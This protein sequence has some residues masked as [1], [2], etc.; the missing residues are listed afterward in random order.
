MEIED[1]IILFAIVF[2]LGALTGFIV[3][4]FYGNHN[5]VKTI[6]VLDSSNVSMNASNIAVEHNTFY[7]TEFSNDV[8][9][10]T[11]RHC[12]ANEQL[13]LACV[14]YGMHYVL[15]YKYIQ[16][17]DDQLKSIHDFDLDK[18]G[19]CEDWSLYISNL[20]N[21][22]HNKG[23]KRLV[24]LKREK[25]Y[26]TTIYELNGTKYDLDGFIYLALPIHNTEV[27]C[28]TIDSN[29]GHCQIMLN[30]PTTPYAIGKAFIIE[31]QNAV[32]DGSSLFDNGVVKKNL[33]YDVYLL[34]NPKSFWYKKWGVWLN[35]SLG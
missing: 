7:S 34:L 13:N 22:Y 32:L 3:A 12:I 1:S 25:D 14:V 17:H 6:D 15:G 2:L 11:E 18:G 33:K 21:Y 16:D 26:T 28:Y 10:F 23:V 4:E 27:F 19:D 35:A 29:K 5:I 20:I 24:V 9:N 8:K 31:P 30:A